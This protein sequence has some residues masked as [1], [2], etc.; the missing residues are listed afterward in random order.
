MAAPAP[1][2]TMTVPAPVAK[3]SA[4]AKPAKRLTLAELRTEVA[5]IDA[6]LEV[7]TRKVEESNAA[8]VAAQKRLVVVRREA[9]AARAVATQAHEDLGRFAAA[10]YRGQQL[11]PVVTVLMGPPAGATDTLRNRQNL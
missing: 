10:A 7:R 2:P 4:P 6:D 5:R 3:P 1:L 11:S 8:L 9:T